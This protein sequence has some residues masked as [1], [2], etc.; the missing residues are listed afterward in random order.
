MRNS[1]SRL[2]GSFNRV[3]MPLLVSC[4]FAALVFVCLWGFGS[5]NPL[6]IE[7]TTMTGMAHKLL[8]AGGV[9]VLLGG[10]IFILSR[11]AL[12]DEHDVPAQRPSWYYPLMSGL[13]SLLCMCVAY[14]FLGMW[15]FGERTGMVVDMHHQYAPLL[16]G[17]RDAILSG[18]LALYNMEVG[19]GANYLSLAAYYLASPLNLLLLVFP[20]NLLAEGILFITLIK[21][22]LCGAMFALCVQKLFGKQ[23]LLIPAVSV[24]YSLMMYLL[25]YSWN[26]MWLDVLMVLPLVVW[27][28]ERLMHTGKFLTYV[29]SL[30]YALFANYYIAFMLC[31]FLVLYYI[32]YCLRARRSGEDVAVSFLRFAGFSVL[33]AGLVAALLVPVFFALRVTSAAGS[34]LPDLNNTL[35]IFEMLGRHLAGTTP[36]IRSGNLPNIYCGVLAALCVP[37][38]ALNKGI[39]LRRRLAFMML[40]LVLAFSFLVNWTDLLWHGLHAPNDL[41]YRF[42]FLY[43]FV[44]LLMT[45][46]TLLHLKDI[47]VKQVLAVFAGAVAYLMVEERFGGEAYTFEIVYVNLA[48][49][50]I[51]TVLLALATRKTLRRRVAYAML[52]LA[53]AAE[54]TLNGGDAILTV[55]ANEYFTKHES[56]VDNVTTDAL[57]KVVARTQEIGDAKYGTGTYRLEFVP[58]RTCVDTA[59]FHY[60]GFTTFSSSNYYTTTKLMG[61]WGYAINGVNSHLYESF[62]PFTDSLL[63]IRYFI[64]EANLSSHPQLTKVDTVTEGDKTYY[65]YENA[66]ALSLGY[67]VD[68]AIKDYEYTKY[69]PFASLED[70]YGALTDTYLPL[71]S[72]NPFTADVV[73]GAEQGFTATSFRVQP[74]G[75]GTAATFTATVQTAGQVYVYV[76]CMAAEDMSVSSGSNTWDASPHEPY[77]VDAGV[78]NV[79]DTVTLSVTADKFCSGNFYVMT[80]NEDAYR[81][82]MDVL[83]RDPLVISEL[84]NG[85]V[86]GTVNADVDGTLMTSIPYDA[87]W[88]V[89]VDGVVVD[90]VAIGEGLL[91]FDVTAGDH[92]VEMEYYPRGW[93]VGLGISGVSLLVLVVLLIVL[94]EKPPVYTVQA[95]VLPI[96]EGFAEEREPLAD[97]P[98]LPDTFA[99]LTAE[100]VPIDTEEILPSTE[101]E[102]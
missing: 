15:P 73:T 16:S 34:G 27:G 66:D 95:S 85:Y 89:R 88:T 11:E 43:S 54:M 83:D 12:R 21:N 91:G 77:I 68:S 45:Y 1:P 57:R 56:Y 55:N 82:G 26:I 58:R 13:L 48:L 14:S 33:A 8:C 53:V 99:E 6:E 38:F 29:L 46:E 52:L 40:W 76:D 84:R 75:D 79:G 47:T 86:N 61:A 67:V 100:E 5:W 42:S 64:S 60:Q 49:V 62:M 80:L 20:E 74:L 90:T 65:I 97:L 2:T 39:P 51:Y 94:R 18:D 44:L 36:T 71:F 87:G 72:Q 19:L 25:A 37:L 96:Q 7:T 4:G 35:D 17:L 70:L 93:W 10:L 24:M 32:T 41:P 102:D 31:I 81:A 63:G 30:S 9:S 98:P 92:T 22:A 23:T 28:F 78:L 59:L 50:S 101:T 3:V 69:D